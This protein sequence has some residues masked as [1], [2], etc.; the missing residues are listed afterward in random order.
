MQSVL[1]LDEA[2]RGSVLGPLVIG[3]FAIDAD[4]IPRLLDLGV[5]DSKLLPADR[6]EK[7]YAELPGFGDCRSVHLG[8]ARIDAAV[9][10]HGL[11]DLELATFAEIVRAVGPAETRAD[12]CDPNARRFARTLK[13]LSGSEAP[14]KARHH[15]DRDDLVVGAASIVAKVERDRAIARLAAE[16]GEPV[17]S[18]YPS[19]PRTMQF[20]RRWT[21]ARGARGT[22]WLRQSWDPTKRLMRERWARRLEEFDE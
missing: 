2:G 4:A 15:M 6:R 21:A 13:A 20:L 16:I 11:N 3:A 8:P 19:D 5:R 17:G 7:I 9:A 12:A 14:V 10:K 18:G 22:S 1:G